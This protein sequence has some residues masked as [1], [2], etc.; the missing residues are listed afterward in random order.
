MKTKG[1]ICELIKSISEEKQ[2]CSQAA[3]NDS[4]KSERGGLSIEVMRNLGSW[5]FFE[6]LCAK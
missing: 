4:R 2:H 3:A 1:W 5:E 6:I